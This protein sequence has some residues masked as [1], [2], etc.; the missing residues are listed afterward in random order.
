MEYSSMTKIIL[1]GASG[2]IGTQTL[3]IISDYEEEL[4]LVAF[5]VGKRI[6]V[7]DTILSQHRHVKA[8]CIQDNNHIDKLSALYPDIVFFHGNQGLIDMIE[9]NDADMVVNA[10]VGFIGFAPTLKSLELGKD[11]ALANKESLVVGGQLIKDVLKKSKAKIYP[12]DSEHVSLTKLLHK[13]NK[14]DIKRIILTA[15]GGAL[16]DYRRDQLI[17]VTVNEALN[18]PTWKMGHRITIDSATMMNK[19]FEIIEAHY[20]FNFSLD[21]IDVVIHPNSQVHGIIEFYDGTYMAELG[22]ND[23]HIAISYALFRGQRKPIKN[24][25]FSFI[26]AEPMV[27]KTVIH[28]RYPS[29]GLALHAAQIKHSLPTV[30]NAADEVAVNAFLS[31]QLPFGEIET[32]ILNTMK[33]HQLIKNPTVDDLIRIDEQ[34]RVIAQRII[35][36]NYL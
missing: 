13:R 19:G 35:K 18:H 2:S 16:R 12:I 29:L 23:M 34:T 20:L 22:P 28:D 4:S 31:G 6:E 25:K 15:S 8:I 3:D 21:K 7:I 36:E 30:L 26:N 1:L 5:S 9:N 27:F 32:I 17:G 11:V 24:I 33:Q 14:K 10:L